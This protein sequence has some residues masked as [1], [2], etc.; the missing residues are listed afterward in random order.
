MKIMIT[1]DQ[2]TAVHSF[3]G[4]AGR[5]GSPDRNDCVQALQSAVQRA[6][7]ADLQ[8]AREAR[9]SQRTDGWQEVAPECG[10]RY[11]R[12]CDYGSRARKVLLRGGA[13]RLVW[14][15]GYSWS[16]GISSGYHP[17][18]LSLFGHPDDTHGLGWILLEGGRLTRKRLDAE[19]PLAPKASSWPTV[20]SFLEH[21]FG[22]DTL[23][24][25]R[26]GRTFVFDESFLGTPLAVKHR[27]RL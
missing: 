3:E 23:P 14:Q 4:P 22:V 2:G 10:P 27:G 19:R 7:E 17:A 13:L 20:T 18:T 21:I 15:G 1:T 16:R 12:G 25:L 11:E 6:Y 24:D 9:N 8:E 5:E 26:P